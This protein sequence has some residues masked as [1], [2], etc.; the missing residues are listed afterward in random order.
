[1]RTLDERF[2][3]FKQAID[4]L[5]KALA[6]SDG[7]QK[8]AAS[9]KA[10]EAATDL[11]RTLSANDQPPWLGP[12]IEALT[13]HGAG[14]PHDGHSYQL[15][16][17]V[18][19]Q[20]LPIQSHT[21]SFA[22][23]DSTAFDFDRLYEQFREQSRVPELFDELIA[24]LQQI[25]S[26]PDIDSVKVVKALEKLIE[27]LKRNRKGSYFSVVATW[28]FAVGLFRNWLWEELCRLPAVGGFLKALR[29]S[30]DDTNKE[31]EKLHAEMQ[32]E[33]RN[34]ITTEVTLLTY[35]HRGLP[36][37]AK[38]R[39]IEDHSTPASG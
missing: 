15:M 20:F 8:V 14:L 39:L 27:T 7:P 35:N 33:V 1:M 26:C 23:T 5:L 22:E 10:L 12:F 30:L 9:S 18:A 37:L 36:D 17:T 6:G 28:D 16:R 24:V 3:A 25:L 32:Q 4:K 38:V 21:W 29:K 19:I 31:M 34:Q 13:N 11:R 2:N